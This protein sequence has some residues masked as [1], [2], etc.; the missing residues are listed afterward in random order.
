MT[1]ETWVA[2]THPRLSREPRCDAHRRYLAGRD[3]HLD[4]AKR[5]RPGAFK[6]EMVLPV[7]KAGQLLVIVKRRIDRKRYHILGT[8]DVLFNADSLQVSDQVLICEA[9]LDAI[10]AARELPNWAVVAP[11]AGCWSWPERY[12]AQ[13]TAR[14]RLVTGYDN[15]ATGNEAAAFLFPFVFPGRTP[16]IARRSGHRR[17]LA[18]GPGLF[19][20][21]EAEPS[22]AP[23]L[24]DVAETSRLT[25]LTFSGV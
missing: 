25:V 19:P 14:K 6:L 11:I 7:Y 18:Y 24:I 1:D 5:W 23:G 22:L 4:D 13:I 16:A 10:I 12:M 21:L 3:I 17:H 8:A 9:P 20:R 15:D 2:T